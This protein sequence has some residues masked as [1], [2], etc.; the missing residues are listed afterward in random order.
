MNQD[1]VKDVY[2]KTPNLSD[3]AIIGYNAGVR[4]FRKSG[5]RIEREEFK[6]KTIIHNYGYGGS[7][8]TLCWGGAEIVKELLGNEK[9]PIAIIGAGV[10]GLACAYTLIK[11]GIKITIYSDKFSP[12]LTSNV[13]AGIISYPVVFGDVSEKRKLF[14][15]KLFDISTQRYLSH[16]DRPE[17]AGT[18]VLN[19]YFFTENSEYPHDFL[20]E[21]R[22]CALQE[23]KVNV[24]FDN[25]LTKSAICRRVFG[26]DGKLFLA[27][28]E[29][30]V[31][32]KGI[33]FIKKF[34]QHKAD[35]LKLNENII[36]NC[37]SFGSKL[38]MEDDE[39]LSVRGQLVYFKPQAGIEY[40]TYET[41]DDPHFWIKIYPW[42]DRLILNGVYEENRSHAKVD[43]E[44]ANKMIKYAR[45]AFSI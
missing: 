19:D 44:V 6:D 36:I 37:T 40:A 34:F 33:P 31:K 15:A 42:A 30:K 23:Q 14:L 17:F 18:R 1:L 11:S 10:V 13:A 9:Q 16:L 35:L 27:D 25:G 41:T 26:L 29:A 32:A 8:L 43:L 28:L 20:N 21:Y 4:P 39:F 22:N 3:D 24:H 45:E 12:N 2:L 7:G 38:L 5:V